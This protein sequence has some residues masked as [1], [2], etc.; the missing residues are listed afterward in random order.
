MEK[1]TEA[2]QN[3]K[4]VLGD[5]FPK[6]RYI[7]YLRKALNHPSD[8]FNRLI[9]LMLKLES[10]EVEKLIDAVDIFDKYFPDDNDG[11]KTWMFNSK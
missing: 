5:Q 6:I 2:Q 4:D 8:V 7:S 10:S 3:I 11:W 1:M 9:S